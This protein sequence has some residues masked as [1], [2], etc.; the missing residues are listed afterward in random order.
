MSDWFF[1]SL[2]DRSNY[3]LV[4]GILNVTPDSFSDGG[5]YTSVDAAMRHGLAMHSQGA[6]IIDVGAESTRPGAENVSADVQFARA[7]PVIQALHAAAPDAAISIDTRDARVAHVA[8]QAGACLINDVSALRDDPD[9]ATVAAAAGAG[10]VLMHRRGDARTMQVGDGPVYDDVVAEVSEFLKE[11]AGFAMA[12]G[13]RADRIMIDPGIGFGKR[14]ED[15][16]RLL[17]A[18]DQL[19]SL[20]FPVL[21]G[22]SRKAFLGRLLEAMN[23][24]GGAAEPNDRLHGSL[25]C[26]AWAMLAGAAM[27]RVHDVRPT[28]DLLATLRAIK[29]RDSGPSKARHY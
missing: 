20:G 3:P 24:R 2:Q 28:V 22:A 16:L 27:V 12:Q 25:A 13:I 29:G 5:R 19:V 23:A 8:I 21:I 11:R 18:I 10:V 6:A 26:A 15:N 4:M 14:F 17:G 7:I 9:M 1:Q